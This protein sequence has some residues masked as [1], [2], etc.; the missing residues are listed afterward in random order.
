[1]P[2]GM[3]PTADTAAGML[4]DLEE[5]GLKCLWSVSSVSRCQWARALAAIVMLVPEEKILGRRRKISR[6]SER[7]S[8]SRETVERF[9]R[10]G[11]DVRKRSQ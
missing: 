11:T 5:G 4:A 10:E 9:E 1:M 7:R 3:P 8:D 6:W 2:L